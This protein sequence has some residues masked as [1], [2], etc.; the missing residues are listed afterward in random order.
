MQARNVL[1]GVALL[2]ETLIDPFIT[3]GEH[4]AT[5]VAGGVV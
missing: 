4:Y 1:G 5:W 3:S 2:Y